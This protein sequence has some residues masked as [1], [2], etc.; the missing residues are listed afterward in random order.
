MVPHGHRARGLQITLTERAPSPTRLWVATATAA[1]TV[2]AGW[3][4]AA[5][6]LLLTTP[7][8]IRIKRLR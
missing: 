2:P 6:A 8:H 3:P 1:G 5:A 4:A 7:I